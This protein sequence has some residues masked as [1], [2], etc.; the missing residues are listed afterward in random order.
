LSDDPLPRVK[1]AKSIRDLRVA[2]ID[3]GV[4]V[5]TLDSIQSDTDIFSPAK[6]KR[7]ETFKANLD[8]DTTKESITQVLFEG[9]S[10]GTADERALIYFLLVHEGKAE[11]KP[12]YFRL[13]DLTYCG[14]AGKGGM[15]FAFR[16]GARKSIAIS[17]D[18]FEACG[19]QVGGYDQVDTIKYERG[20][21]RYFKGPKRNESEMNRMDF[22]DTDG[23]DTTP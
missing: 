12:A 13:F 20:T 9:A 2:L 23:V 21:Y 18:V 15:T 1:A 7:A 4:P 16:G 10:G 11:G 19:L 5:K 17:L 14:Y 3:L 6:L 8:G 22:T